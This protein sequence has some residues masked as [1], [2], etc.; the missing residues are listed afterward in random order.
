MHWTWA[1]STWHERAGWIRLHVWNRY[2]SDIGALTLFQLHPF[3]LKRIL[4]GSDWHPTFS[5]EP[6]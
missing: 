6:K 5:T 3:G 4:E 1:N 2:V